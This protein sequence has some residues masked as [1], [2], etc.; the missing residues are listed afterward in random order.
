[1]G[2]STLYYLKPGSR[3]HQFATLYQDS[4]HSLIRRHV[5]SAC[6][7]FF[8]DTI[9]TKAQSQPDNWRW[10]LEDQEFKA[11]LNYT[12]SEVGLGYMRCFENSKN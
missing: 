7:P 9:S 5:S 10:R 2:R 3:A 11:I 1:M 8:S 4:L 6:L 12:D